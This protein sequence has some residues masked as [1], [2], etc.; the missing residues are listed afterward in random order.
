[1]KISTLSIGDELI[2]GRVTDTNAGTIAAA[3]IEHGMRVWRHIGVGDSEADIIAALDELS[4]SSETLIVSGGLGPTED[5]LTARA[6]A[7]ASGRR[8]VINEEALAHVR[9]MHTRLSRSI[10]SVRAERQALLPADVA[11]IHNPGGTA[12][13]FSLEHNGCNMY[14]MPGVP[15]E[16]VRMLNES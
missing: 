6:A 14:F 15:S 12:C 2:C 13:G 11:L 10:S 1:M 8:L 4:R 5:D 9:A 3:L 7:A 16:M